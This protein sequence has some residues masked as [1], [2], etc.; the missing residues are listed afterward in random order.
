MKVESYRDAFKRA[1][2]TKPEY[3]A[4]FVKPSHKLKLS[5]K[6]FNPSHVLGE[7][8]V[9]DTHITINKELLA[10]Y[11]ELK[12][13][14][15]DLNFDEFLAGIISHEFIHYL[16]H[17]EVGYVETVTFD[18][19]YGEINKKTILKNKDFIGCGF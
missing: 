2:E 6:K 11:E 4:L 12:L 7:Y 18:N 3:Y 9:I 5:F 10:Y 15:P 1:L 13:E 16:I 19:V 8:D 14:I 17:K